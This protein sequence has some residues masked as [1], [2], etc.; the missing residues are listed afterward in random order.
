MNRLT[1]ELVRGILGEEMA[2]RKETIG[3]FAGG[4]KPPTTGHLEVVQKALN[5]HPE[6]DKMIIYVGSGERD[7]INQDESVAIWRIYQKYLP[8]KVEVQP[9]PEG[10]PPI[11][12]VYSY[13]KNNPDKNI[14]WFLGEREGNKDDFYDFLKRVRALKKGNYPNMQ[15][16]KV[17]TPDA[18]SGTK[19]RKALLARNK[20]T[21]L[22]YIPDIPEKEEIWSMLSEIMGIMENQNSIKLNDQV[23][24]RKGAFVYNKGKKLYLKSR[25]LFVVKDEVED[26]ITLEDQKGRQFWI[27]KHEMDSNWAKF[28]PIQ[29]PLHERIAYDAIP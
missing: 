21:F 20:E 6:I 9:S 26:R 12:A 28:D 4:F 15:A 13:A 29:V 5:D 22:A 3:I 19:A 11:G 25:R 7:S 24:A 14:Y 1:D 10:K 27:M 2:P 16:K 17:I 23:L 8:S 18:V